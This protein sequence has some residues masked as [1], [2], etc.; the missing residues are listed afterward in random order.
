MSRRTFQVFNGAM[1]TTARIPLVTTGTAIKTMLQIKPTTQITVTEWGFSFDVAPSALVSVE[2]L[3]TGTV[4]VV[5]LTDFV[6]AD[7]IKVNDPGTA[8]SAISLAAEAS[9]YTSSSTEGTIVATRVLDYKPTWAQDY[10]KQK[11]LDRDWG[12]AANDFLRIR[13]TTAT[14]INMLCWFEWEE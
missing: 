13:V 6:A 4:G 14:A 8:A 2:L 11:P 7:I 10:S 1:P 3:T 5:A 9:G 12:V